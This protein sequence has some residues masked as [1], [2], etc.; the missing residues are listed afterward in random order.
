MKW[1]WIAL[2]AVSFL[3]FAPLAGLFSQFSLTDF[4]EM[5]ASR[6][7]LKALK[8]TLE[9]GIIGS[10][11]SV[12]FGLLFARKFALYDWKGKR[13]ER[14]ALLM[15]YLIP[16]FILATAFVVGWNPTSGLIN[17]LISF[18]GGLYGLI[19][20]T[21]LFSVVHLPVAFL[22]LEDRFKKIDGSL[23]EAA[24]LSG[25][26][27]I[28]ILC[29]IEIP[30]VLPTLVGAFA[31]CFALDVSAFAI[32][33]WIGAPEKA[34]PLAYKIYQAIEVGGA[35]GIPRAAGLSIVLFVLVIPILL[36]GSCV[37][38]DESKFILVSGKAARVAEQKADPLDLAL[39]RI[40]FWVW[41]LAFWIAPLF[42]LFLSTLVKPG[43]LQEFGASCLKDA[44]LHTYHYVLF[45]L[46]ET[47]LGFLGSMIYGTLSAVIIA[48]GAFGLLLLFVKSRKVSRIADWVFTVP[49]ST[50]GAIIALGL[51]VTCSGKYG[52]NLYNTAWIVVAA[53]ILKHFNLAY[54][55]M[56]NGLSN[57]SKSLFEAA[58]LS[59]ANRF[60]VWSKIL[61]PML[62]PEITGGFFLVLIP[63]IGELTMSV[64][65]VSPKFRSI[66]TVLF[67]LQDY[68]DQSSAAA[69]SV[70]LIILI[71]M[72]NEL[73]RLISRGKLGY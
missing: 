41:Q 51:I 34:Y 50:P 7:F 9:S 14:L 22:L 59:G 25:A 2:L 60:Q 27:P 45:D 71:L 32:P 48:L 3:F 64:F 18:P 65:L 13:V 31:L 21:V 16:N 30:L 70:L 42:V 67:D 69:L 36:V 11:F 47:Q 57:I 52:I 55:P 23:R 6:G 68:A 17:P 49:V 63:I 8:V 20:M 44:S 12:F 28:K 26:G 61:V 73:T 43:C 46:N 24:K 35:D 5:L 72:V 39:F 53:Y 10:A 15:P 56:K 19:G 29:S 4:R 40:F 1:V 62:K 66:G 58:E 37:Q 33:A 38:R 54:Q